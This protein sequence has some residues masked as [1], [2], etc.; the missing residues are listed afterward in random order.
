MPWRRCAGTAS[1]TRWSTPESSARWARS[2]PG[3]HG[4]P[5]FQHPR[6]EDAY[7]SLTPL[8]GRCLATSGDYATSFTPDR[9]DNH[10]FD[11]RTGRSPTELASVSVLASSGL[12]ADG[13]STAV[14]VLGLERGLRLIDST[15][16]ADALLVLKDGRTLATPG[17][18]ERT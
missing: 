10:L 8:D 6:V 11:P 16:H 1:S 13:L 12:L 3:H 9:R 2:R 5:A 7:V 4:R 18:P 17:F 14:F 15:P